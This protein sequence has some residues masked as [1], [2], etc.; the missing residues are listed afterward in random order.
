MALLF[1]QDKVM[2]CREESATSNTVNLLSPGGMLTPPAS[3]RKSLDV[4]GASA[5]SETKPT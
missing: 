5:V 1:F 4:A 2:K 3:S